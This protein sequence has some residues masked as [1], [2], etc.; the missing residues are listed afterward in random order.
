[1]NNDP[2]T[3][4]F[5][6]D[7]FSALVNAPYGQAWKA[8][9]KHDPLFGRTS[10]ERFK[11]LVTLEQDCPMRAHAFVEACSEDEARELAENLPFNDL[12]WNVIDCAA[13][14]GFDVVDVEPAP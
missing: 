12:D 1:M 5:S 8:I 3:G 10:G 6:R 7:E 2:V 4:P 13:A 11:W 9:R 14:Y